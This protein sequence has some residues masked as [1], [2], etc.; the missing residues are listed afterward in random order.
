[1]NIV[2]PAESHEGLVSELKNLLDKASE[3]TSQHHTEGDSDE[4]VSAASDSD[5]DAAQRAV[6]TGSVAIED[7]VLRGLD[8]CTTTMMD[9]R[10]LLDEAIHDAFV[11]PSKAATRK[12]AGNFKVTD[13]AR[14]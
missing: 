3:I 12:E 13:V 9:I 10:P 8:I 1:L 7:E 5:G 11:R 6:E 2:D 4:A 14:S